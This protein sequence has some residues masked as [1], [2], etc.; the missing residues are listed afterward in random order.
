MLSNFIIANG[1]LAGFHVFRFS[2]FVEKKIIKVL[3]R[4][5]LF[6]VTKRGRNSSRERVKSFYESFSAELVARGV[7]NAPSADL[8]S[9]CMFSWRFAIF[10][11]LLMIFVWFIFFPSVVLKKTR[12][13]S[14]YPRTFCLFRKIKVKSYQ[15]NS[16]AFRQESWKRF[17]HI[18]SF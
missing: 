11:S 6:V 2:L 14:F 9:L 10:N 15:K 16:E 3:K 12:H 18:F 8:S 5:S 7:L 1:F 17:F 4:K 13:F